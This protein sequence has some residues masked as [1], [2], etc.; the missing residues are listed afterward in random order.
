M[1]IDTP[2]A[3]IIKPVKQKKEPIRPNFST[4]LPS[5]STQT[6]NQAAY[7]PITVTS[8]RGKVLNVAQW[9]TANYEYRN[10]E[11][12]MWDDRVKLTYD[13]VRSANNNRA[14]I[15]KSDLAFADNPIVHQIY[16]SLFSLNVR[17]LLKEFPTTAKFREYIKAKPAEFLK[18]CFGITFGNTPEAYKEWVS[19]CEERGI[20]YY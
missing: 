15:D 8:A 5:I 19:Y 14:L 4:P 11:H 18:T 7:A 13:A 1:A 2:T 12:F 3:P 17:P 16:I 6:L 20:L 10:S 9:F